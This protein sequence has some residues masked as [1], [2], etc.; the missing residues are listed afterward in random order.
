VDLD[1]APNIQCHE[2]QL[3]LFELDALAL[4]DFVQIQATR[5]GAEQV[6][7]VL[8]VQEVLVISFKFISL[9]SVK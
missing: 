9:F 4:H 5:E 8:H 3:H 6:Q 7:W 2:I 1:P